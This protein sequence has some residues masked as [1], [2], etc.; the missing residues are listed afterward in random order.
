MDKPCILLKIHFLEFLAEIC[1][2]WS[3]DFCVD[4]RQAVYLNACF[5]R[6]LPVCPEACT[7]C[8]PVYC[9]IDGCWLWLFFVKIARTVLLYMWLFKRN[10]QFYLVPGGSFGVLY[11]VPME[12]CQV[13]SDSAVEPS[14]PLGGLDRPISRLTCDV[15]RVRRQVNHCTSEETF[16]CVPVSKWF[17][18]CPPSANLSVSL[19]VVLA[20]TVV[21]RYE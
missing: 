18:R 11:C 1:G 19:S 7:F 3:P 8:V 14:S 21:Q 13:R 16:F 15:N 17:S 20:L 6:C 5:V 4:A 9:R 12:L 10:R 2:F